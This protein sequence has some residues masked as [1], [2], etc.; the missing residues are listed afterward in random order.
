MR[1]KLYWISFYFHTRKIAWGV[2]I[3]TPTSPNWRPHVPKPR[4]PF[5]WPCGLLSVSPSLSYLF[6]IGNLK[7][8]RP[9]APTP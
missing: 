7:G 1:S 2:K 3:H 8:L 5:P 4:L 9:R 6:F